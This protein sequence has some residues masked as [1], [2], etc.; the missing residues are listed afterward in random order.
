MFRKISIEIPVTAIIAFALLFYSCAGNAVDEHTHEAQ[1][2]TCPMHPQVVQQQQGTCPLCGMDLVAFDKSKKEKFL[3]LSRNQQLLANVSTVILRNSSFENQTYL[4]GRLLVNPELTK[5]ISSR[6]SGRIEELYLKE[7]GIQVKKGQPLYKMYSEQLQTLQNE[8]L[9]MEEQARRLPQEK[10]FKELANAARQK[11][12]LYGQTDIQLNRLLQNG[13]AYPYATF[14]APA[15]GLISELAIVEGDYVAEGSSLMMLEDY[16]RLWVEAD[17]YPDEVAKIKMGDKL[18]VVI[19]GFE[20]ESVSTTVNF[21]GPA[22]AAGS[23]TVQIRG[24][25]EN[26]NNWQPGL[27]VNLLLPSESHKDYFSLPIDAV[28]RDAET[29]HV[30]VETRR[31]RFEPRTV[32]TGVES[33]ERIEVL[34]GIKAGDKVVVSG[35][36]LLYSEYILKRG[37]HPVSVAN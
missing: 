34:N 6:I 22:L 23:Q 1:T 4:N 36:Y 18:K 3:T 10:R 20:T 11:L 14:L 31:G 27:Q 9:L 13:A 30:W 7:T 33:S 35:A 21:I 25:I 15:S 12:I 28:I 8:F 2:F 37:E 5:D 32:I 17:V 16:T 24:L 26:K 29:K 19:P